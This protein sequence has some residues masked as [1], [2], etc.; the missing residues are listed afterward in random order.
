LEKVRG[1]IIVAAARAQEVP[2]RRR[3]LRQELIGRDIAQ[4]G[5]HVYLRVRANQSIIFHR[6]FVAICG[7][8]RPR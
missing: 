7:V 3:V 4:G 1:H 2:E 8:L 5:R 6:G